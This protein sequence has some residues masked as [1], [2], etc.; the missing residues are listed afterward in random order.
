MERQRGMI[1]ISD[2][3]SQKHIL[4]N[5]EDDAKEHLVERIAEAL[6]KDPRVTDWEQFYSGL[7][8]GTSCMA[9]ENG[10]VLCIAHARTT[11]VSAMTMA[12][13]RAVIQPADD[14][15]GTPAASFTPI[16][17]IFVIGV[18]VALASDYLRIIGALARI[19]HTDRGEIAL[20]NATDPA[21]FLDSLRTLE[22]AL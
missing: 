3:L 22:M 2:T 21:E 4:L 14:A 8:K 12:V 20:A 7:E 15:P 18:P 5:L 9:K 6:K 11:A 19:F 16:R 10:S 13:G 1:T 17:L